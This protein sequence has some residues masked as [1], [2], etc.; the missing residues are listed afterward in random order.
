MPTLNYT[1]TV[2]PLKTVGEI[3]TLLVSHGA[4]AI[5]T[6]Y[7]EQQPVGISFRLPTPHGPREYSL[8]VHSE[9]VFKVLMTEW[10]AGKIRRSYAT[11]EQATRT[12]WRVLKDWLEAQLAI[13]EA[14][15]LSFDQV[16]LPYMHAG[17]NLT[18]YEKYVE[19]EESLRELAP[20][21]Q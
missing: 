3:Q 7:R 21:V 6:N 17:D 14:H 1:S 10:N 12:A 16:M 19:R 18:V 5:V 4:D 2:N 8:P 11:R 13:I 9:P 20:G 15:M